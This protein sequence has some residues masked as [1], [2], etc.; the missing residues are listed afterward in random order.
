M[1]FQPAGDKIDRNKCISKSKTGEWKDNKCDTL[2]VESDLGELQ[3]ECQCLDLSPATVIE[4][5]ENMFENSL[6]K[7][8]FSD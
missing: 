6:A 3:I 7:E 8:V 2:E 4:D 5:L 1:Q